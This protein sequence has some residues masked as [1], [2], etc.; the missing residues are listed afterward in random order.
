MAH[1]R[2]A[3]MDINE[4][5]RLLRAGESDRMI[6]RVLGH[7]RRTVVRYRDWARERGLLEGESPTPAALHRLLDETLPVQLPPQ[8]TSTVAVYAGEIAELRSRG[9]EV[10]AIRARL[11]E[12]HG[13]PVSYSAVWR[14]VQRLEPRETEPVVRVE[15]PPGGEAQVD[16]GY[17][18]ITTDGSGRERKTWVFV[19]VLGYSRHMYAEFVFDQRVETWLLCHAHAF[20][21]FG[22]V[23]H[24][25]VPDNLKAAVVRASFGGE[26]LAQ[27]SYR[28]CAT[29]YG[30]LIDPNPPRSP[31]LKGK[32][33]Q[34][35]VHYIKRNFLAGRDLPISR[36]ELNRS[37]WGWIES[38]AGRRVHGTTREQP[39]ERFDRA[40]RT[41]LLPLPRAPF[42]PAIWKRATV[43]RDCYV[44]F[45]GSYYSA[46]YRLVGR[47]VWVRGGARTVELYTDEHELV[48]THD[49]A[50]SPGVRRTHLAH[51]P[52]EK[53]P[54]LALSREGCR[55][56]AA[57]IGPETQAAVGRLLD[58][59]PEDRLRSAGRLLRL[60]GSYGPERLE[61]ACERA[62]HYGEADYPTVRRILE[63]GLEDEPLGGQGA[64]AQPPGRYAFV[65]QAGEFVTSL[66][67][68]A[69]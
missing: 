42:D 35:G 67:G 11:E 7:N 44:T 21:Y 1:R 12:R 47:G 62:H 51:L 66:L 19:M 52:P 58:H 63:S 53:V 33:E 49:R 45:E 3:T 4:L 14:L 43:Y 25:V 46:P 17:A 32:V 65:R 69:R 37:L 24:R 38:T 26:A 18:G 56:R 31:H 68:V 22:G 20:S 40:E 2:L 61:R 39:L 57:S 55:L 15:T 30:L 36:D 10:A 54:G 23:P 5:V 6:A 59:R 9:V 64:A 41:A 8:Q 29:H 13:H 16:F 34:G 27:R 60:S 48:A 28:E 50:D